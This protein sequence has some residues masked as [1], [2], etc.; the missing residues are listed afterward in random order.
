[1]RWIRCFRDAFHIFLN[2]KIQQASE[3][4][5][6]ER[7]YEHNFELEYYLYTHSRICHTSLSMILFQRAQ[8]YLK[9]FVCDIKSQSKA[10]RQQSN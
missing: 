5:F 2:N 6:E 4:A 8:I 3:K 10:N 9:L 7:Y 1:M